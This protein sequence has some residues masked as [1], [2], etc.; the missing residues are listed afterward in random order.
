MTNPT[1][2]AATHAGMYAEALANLSA[3]R[4]ALVAAE[5][6]E[7]TALDAGLANPSEASRTAFR[8]AVLARQDAAK[9]LRVAEATE[10]DLRP[11][12]ARK[13]KVTGLD[14][15]QKCGGYGMV[16]SSI[17]AGRCWNCGGS[18]RRGC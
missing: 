3:A 8:S 16:A 6:T 15:C 4:A 17:D 14:A 2:A 11:Y 7:T 5:A 9:A 1:D 12:A 18:G 10:Y 13:P